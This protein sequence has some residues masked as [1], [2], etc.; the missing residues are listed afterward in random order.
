MSLSSSSVGHSPWFL[1]T[2]PSSPTVIS[3]SWS[4][5]KREKASFRQSSSASESLVGSLVEK[6][7]DLKRK[8]I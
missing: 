2:L 3:P 7:S 1:M 5:S 8:K 6:D 4:A